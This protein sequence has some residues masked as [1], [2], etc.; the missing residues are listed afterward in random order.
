MYLKYQG[1][2]FYGIQT[3]YKI[4]KK[5][6]LK[7]LCFRKMP[8]KTKTSLR[9]QKYANRAI[10]SSRNALLED[11]CEGMF[12]AYLNNGQ[13]L[14]YGHVTNLLSEL[15][16]KEKWLS[17]NIINKAFM[18]YR[19]KKKNKVLEKEVNPVPDSISGIGTNVSTLSDLSNVSSTNETGAWKVGRP[20][21]STEAKKEAEKRN[22]IAAKK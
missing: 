1:Y 10:Q 6:I 4:K 18:K 17:R 8:R 15:Q 13:R 14:P 12:E 2:V 21:G 9:V 3:D 16:T 5:F 19:H 22:I 20:V 11:V 7:Y